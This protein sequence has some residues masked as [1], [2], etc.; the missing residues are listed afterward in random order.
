MI[1]WTLIAEILFAQ[2]VT[3]PS[4]QITHTNIRT[5][6]TGQSCLYYALNV[7]KHLLALRWKGTLWPGEHET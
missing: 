1:K 3:C 6:L 5:I 7:S 2:K 4:V